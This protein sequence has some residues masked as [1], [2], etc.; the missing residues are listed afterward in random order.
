AGTL[1]L[2][3]TDPADGVTDNAEAHLED[4]EAGD[5]V[6]FGVKFG[7]GLKGMVFPPVDPMCHN[8]EKVRAEFDGGSFETVAGADLI[9]R[10]KA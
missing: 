4:L 7:P 10:P 3:D 1:F 8:D 9:V 5:M 2:T 6:L